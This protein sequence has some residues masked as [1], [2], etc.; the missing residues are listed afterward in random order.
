MLTIIEH[1][2]GQ[3]VVQ[4]QQVLDNLRKLLIKLPQQPLTRPSQ[5]GPRHR[6]VIALLVKLQAS[7]VI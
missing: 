6:Q 3:R 1:R 4:R 2:P 5:S 7:L